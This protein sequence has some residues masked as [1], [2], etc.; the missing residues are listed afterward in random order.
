M[1]EG[2]CSLGM[3]WMTS[4]KESS[5]IFFLNIIHN[6]DLMRFV[7]YTVWNIEQYRGLFRQNYWP[8]LPTG[9]SDLSV[10]KRFSL[11]TLYIV[12]YANWGAVADND[13]TPRLQGKVLPAVGAAMLWIPPPFKHSSQ[14]FFC[15]F[16]SRIL[17]IQPPPHWWMWSPN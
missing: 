4:W 17:C 5:D 10:V 16:F 2:L 14:G 11:T 15:L 8:D 3:M 13:K 9:W 12:G 6:V 1:L 7:F